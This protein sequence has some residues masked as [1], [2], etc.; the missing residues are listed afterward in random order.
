MA[1]DWETPLIDRKPMATKRL[2]EAGS[3]LVLCPGEELMEV[4]DRSDHDRMYII[5]SGR[6]TGSG[7]PE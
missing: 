4:T 6:R 7:G 2:T 5:V 3:L 1:I